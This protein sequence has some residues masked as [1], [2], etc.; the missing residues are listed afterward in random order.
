MK[1]GAFWTDKGQTPIGATHGLIADNAGFA[2]DP[3]TH[4]ALLTCRHLMAQGDDIGI[5]VGI[6]IAEDGLGE[7][8]CGV[9]M[10]IVPAF[11]AR[12]EEIGIGKGGLGSED[13]RQAKQ[14]DIGGDDAQ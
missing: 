9:R 1:E 3:D 13:P 5:L 11:V 12:H 10:E 14:R 6:G 4:A 8:L 2:I 7:E